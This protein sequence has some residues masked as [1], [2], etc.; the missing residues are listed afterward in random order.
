MSESKLPAVGKPVD[1]ADGRVKVTGKARYAAEYP[2]ANLVHAVL[3]QSTIAKGRMAE[4]D[5]ATAEKL[6]GV[7]AVL[8]HKNAPKLHAVP[9]GPGGTSQSPGT[10]FQL[11]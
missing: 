9:A 1:R 3:V 4:I 2:A 6:P 7:I 5:T 10:E 11:Q 8:T